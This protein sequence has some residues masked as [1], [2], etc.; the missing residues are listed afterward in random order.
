MADALTC[1]N[2]NAS[3]I[4]LLNSA[5]GVVDREEGLIVVMSDESAE[6][7]EPAIDCGRVPLTDPNEILRRMFTKT[8][9]G[10]TAI[11][12]FNVAP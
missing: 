7:V 8:S 11:R 9:D 3:F 4:E 6:D 10:L 5:R 1:V 12:L 2:P